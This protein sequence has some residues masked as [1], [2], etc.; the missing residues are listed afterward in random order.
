MLYLGQDAIFVE[1]CP[2][3]AAHNV[4]HYL[5]ANTG[6]TNWSAILWEA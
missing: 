1:M 3:V 4:L 6:Q 5:A 2:D